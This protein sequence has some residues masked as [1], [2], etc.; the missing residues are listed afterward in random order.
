MTKTQPHESDGEKRE[1]NSDLT[2]HNL[3]FL[4]L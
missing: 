4:H 1:A 2:V 3:K